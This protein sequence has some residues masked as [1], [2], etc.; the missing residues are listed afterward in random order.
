MRRVELTIALATGLAVFGCGGGGGGS[1]G[2]RASGFLGGSG[3]PGIPVTQSCDGFCANQRLSPEQVN[4]V[5]QQAVN[6]A[7]AQGVQATCAV[8]DRVGNPLAVYEMPGAPQTV[9]IGSNNNDLAFPGNGLEDVPGGANQ[10]TAQVATPT[11]LPNL[12]AP[13]SARFAA[14]SK[15]G[16]AA[17]LSTQG[18]A[19]TTR[20]ASQII[21]EHFNPGEFMQAGGPLF[22]VQFSQ[23][24]CGDIA[25]KSP[26]IVPAQGGAGPKRLPLGFAGDPGGVPLYINGDPAGAVGIEVDGIYRV[27]PR[28][29]DDD[30]DIEEII[31]LAAQRSFEASKDRESRQITVMGKLLRYTDLD[32]PNPREIASPPVMDT[33]LTTV[34]G[35]SL[36]DV[37]TLNPNAAANANFFRASGGVVTGRRFLSAESGYLLLEG[38]PN[39]PS[40]NGY[41]NSNLESRMLV[42]PD[43]TAFLGQNIVNPAIDPKSTIPVAGAVNNPRPS[44]SPTPANNGLT[45]QEAGTIVVNAIRVAQKSRAQIRRGIQ[46]PGFPFMQVNISVVDLAGNLNAFS[47]TRD[48]PVFGTTVSIQKARTAAFISRAPNGADPNMPTSAADDLMAD[49]Q[50]TIVPGVVDVNVQT[51]SLGQYVLDARAFLADDTALANGKA[52][53]DRSGGNLSRPF[54]PDGI[55]GN[56]NGP[57]SK[58]ISS[59]SPFNTGLQLDLVITRLLRSLLADPTITSCTGPELLEVRGGI[60]IF[61]GSV[62]IFKNGVLVGGIGISGD[63]VDQ[64]DLI[65]FEGLKQGGIAL[66]P[67]NTRGFGDQPGFVGNAPLAVRSDTIRAAAPGGESGFLRFVNCPPTPFLNSDAQNVCEN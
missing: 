36:V 59:W 5:C 22:G 28:T 35:A 47:G 41:F 44:L 39:D 34:T 31:A 8:V 19:F 23:L 48:A 52:F 11:G 63:G 61:P 15:A 1:G 21:Q 26:E 55:D 14:I 67:A 51:Q 29:A 20:T 17:Y 49:M 53:S 58:P 60:Q 50:E 54:F 13:I 46:G 24:P 66:N 45:A 42:N 25:R 3:S 43:G 6:E 40:K 7:I 64:D 38:D 62:P 32:T 56:A 30:V 37:T 16:T 2:G 27:D 9:R 33:N 18:N 12:S 4:L 57:F 65:A 10:G